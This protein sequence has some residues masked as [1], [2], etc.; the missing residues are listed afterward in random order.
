MHGKMPILGF[1]IGKFAYITDMK[2][3]ADTE[4]PYLEGV[5]TLVVN[6]LRFEKEHH[7]HQLVDDAARF[8]QQ[9]GVKQTYITHVCHHIGLYD[10]ANKR[11]PNGLMLAYDGLKLNVE[12]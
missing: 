9:I 12:Y 2:T 7:S 3:I 4:L 5:E 1:R 11:M 6:A 10:E 8:A